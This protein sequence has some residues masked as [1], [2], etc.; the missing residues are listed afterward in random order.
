MRLGAIERK[1]FAGFLLAMVISLIVG[2][3][4]YQNAARIISTEE[5][6]KHTDEVLDQLDQLLDSLVDLDAGQRGYLLTTNETFLGRVHAA[7]QRIPDQL[8]KLRQLTADNPIQ[9]QQQ[10]PLLRSALKTRLESVNQVIDLRRT[11]GVDAARTMLMDQLNKGYLDESRNILNRLKAEERQLYESRSAADRQSIRRTART[12]GIAFGVQFA[13][14]GLLYWLTHLDVLERRRAEAAL[15]KSSEDLKDARDA[16]LLAAKLKSQFLANMSHEIRTPMNGVLGMTEILL[17]TQLASRQREFAETIQSSAN[18]LLAIINDILDF[19]KIEAGMLRF[20]NSPFN[21]H[22]SVENVIDLFAQLARK[23]DLELALLIEE[24]VPVS[25]K[26]DPVRLRQVLTNLL[27][28]AIKFTDKGEVVLRCRRA[29]EIAGAISVRFEVSDTGIGIAPEDQRL[30]FS[31]FVQADG[32]TTRRFGGTGLGLAICKELVTG[33]GGEIGMESTPGI[34][35]TFWFAAK[36][37]PTETLMPVPT[38]AGDLRNVRVLLVD[39]NA[40][41]RKILHYQ[42]A[43]W[44]M[45]DNAASSGPGALNALRRGAAGGD[46][47]AIVIL[48]THMPELS[49]IQVVEVIRTDPDIAGVK[50]V[51]LTSMEPGELRESVR[52]EVDAFMTKPVKQSQLFETLC[53][54][55]GIKAER[56]E[57]LPAES[58]SSPVADKRLRI[59]L[60]EDNE[61]N[62]RVALYQLRMLDHQVDLARNGVEALKLFD[63]NEYDAVLMDIHMPELD[64]YATTAEIRRR[65]GDRKHTPII[66]M[67]ANALEEDREKCLAAG[68]DEH[69]AKP[70][71]APALVRVLE[72]CVANAEPAN[73]VP[74]SPATD[75]QPL[76]NSGMGDIIP[77]LIEIFLETAPRDIEKAGGALRSSQATDLEDAAH[78]L[79]GSCSNL[80]AA[81]LR[82]L[83]QQ[84]EKL[85]R[86]GSLQSA[87]ELLASVE[88]E[89]SRVRVELVAALDR[90]RV[91]EDTKS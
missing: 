30:L 45:R 12:T 86:N 2:F 17:N 63:E 24:G 87:P 73:I 71:Q 51:L 18:A 47:F 32:S 14:L 85:G 91:E 27:S 6:V 52:G 53:A 58:I 16:A 70:V 55:L 43:S 4:L 36:F 29:S 74:L 28:N 22:R 79:K 80:G 31:P 26:G 76:I 5:W 9:Q 25:V 1:I 7:G 38:A 57:T 82:D 61:V 88:E 21:L 81:R 11:V 15:R 67:T 69:L 46:P 68:M 23:K 3:V 20:E 48:D 33:M 54:V 65:E 64:G 34:G 59:L 66:A 60:A 89:F 50:I 90:H 35:S 8:D 10:I 39:D 72:Q 13:I 78:K 40:T 44:G 62:Q 83:C 37:V 19:S 42:V 56:E 84:L 49:G 41:N 77:R 75:L